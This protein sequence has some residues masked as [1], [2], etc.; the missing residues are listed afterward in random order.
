MLNEH[1][2]LYDFKYPDK[3]MKIK[4]NVD[5]YIEAKKTFISK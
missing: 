2:N 1:G 5:V 3:E 4:S